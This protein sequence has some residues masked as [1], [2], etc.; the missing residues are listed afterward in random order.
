M[1]IDLVIDARCPSQP[2]RSEARYAVLERLLARGDPLTLDA[3]RLE[4]CLQVLF[5]IARSQ[6]LPAAALSLLGDGIDPGEDFWVRLDPVH[7]RAERSRLRL[8]LLPPGDIA[9]HEA[10]ALRAAL[11]AHL[12]QEGYALLAPHAQRWYLRTPRPLELFTQPP[13]ECA[14]ALDERHLPAGADGA[15]MRRLITEA[16]MLLHELP[17]NEA[18]EAAGKLAVNGAWP[19]GG[20]AA[21]ALAPSRYT[22]AFSDDAL[23]RGLARASGAQAEPLPDAAA[24]LPAGIPPQSALLVVCSAAETPLADVE[25]RWAR[26]LAEAVEADRAAELRLVLITAERVLA[27]S[28]ARGSLRRWWR[29]SRPLHHA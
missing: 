11:A 3:T 5:G 15:A 16:Q 21:L 23:V 10:E 27:R 17:V 28:L 2:G 6:P 24:R 19:W 20:G 12:A 1:K 9:S 26:P 18:R 8:V 14:G 29:R 25:R 4:H 7:L 13:D 22:H